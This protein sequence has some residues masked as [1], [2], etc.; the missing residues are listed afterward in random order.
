MI[1]NLKSPNFTPKPGK[2]LFENTQA[3]G[4]KRVANDF[5]SDEYGFSQNY[6]Y[7]AQ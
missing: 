2:K 6:P 1:K 3:Y 4:T 7:K 5:G